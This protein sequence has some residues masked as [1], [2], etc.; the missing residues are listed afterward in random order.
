VRDVAGD[1]LVHAAVGWDGQVSDP[2]GRVFAERFYAGLASGSAV[3]PAF[4]SPLLTVTARW[5]GHAR[6][7]LSGITAIRPLQPLGPA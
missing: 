4:Q 5:P 2:Q 3:G 6:P 1:I 7:R